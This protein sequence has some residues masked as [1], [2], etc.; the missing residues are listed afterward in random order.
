LDGATKLAEEHGFAPPAEGSTN[1]EIAISVLEGTRETADLEIEE[2]TEYVAETQALVQDLSFVLPAFGTALFVFF[3]VLLVAIFYGL[4]TLLLRHLLKPC[5]YLG[6]PYILVGLLL[7]A[8]SSLDLAS[9]ANEFV[10]IPEEYSFVFDILVAPI[11]SSGLI[12]LIIGGILVV[13][14]T[15]GLILIKAL[16]KKPAVAVAVAGDAPMQEEIESADAEEDVVNEEQEETEMPAE[17][18]EEAPQAEETPNEEAPQVPV[19]PNCGKAVGDTPF[20]TGC[21]TR[22]KQ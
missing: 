13:G 4:F 7:L 12:A 19:C 8:I 14:S 17:P 15:A 11:F 16:R 3:N 6:I 9:I 18:S 20:C 10:S 21:G 5:V 1:L 2:I 22:L